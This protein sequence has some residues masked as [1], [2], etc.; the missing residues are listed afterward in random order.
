MNR[1]ALLILNVLFLVLAFTKIALADDDDITPKIQVNGSGSVMVEPDTAFINVT[2]ETSAKTAAEAASQNAAKSQNVLKAIKSV[3]GKEDKVSTVFYNLS[4][5]YEYN[6]TTRKSELVGYTATNSL[7][8][9]TR[10]LDKVGEIIDKS[11]AAG[12]NN[13]GSLQFSASKRDA[14][15]KQALTKAVKDARETA[16]IV[17]EA[18]GIKIV[19]I[20]NISPSYNFPIP[21][22]RNFAAAGKLAMES[23]PTPIEAGELT[24]TAN[25]NITFE[26]Q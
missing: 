19:R 12:A 20:L 26:I 8:I 1:K 17:A 10:K 5:R 15:T 9:E 25:V 6:N 14:L 24:V 3:I 13:I 16:E 18:A 4:P 21:L 2:A 22:D 11:V 23:A 7:S